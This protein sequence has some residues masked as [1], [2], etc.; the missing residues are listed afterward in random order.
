MSDVYFCDVCEKEIKRVLYYQSL[1][2]EILSPHGEDN[3]EYTVYFCGPVCSLEWAEKFGF[4]VKDDK[5]NKSLRN[6]KG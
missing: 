4:L 5:P 3:N 2:G 6:T 1:R